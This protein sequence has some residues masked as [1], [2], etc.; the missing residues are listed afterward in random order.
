[1]SLIELFCDVDDF[2]KTFVPKWEQKQLQ[3][4]SRKRLR[5]SQLSLSEI[6]TIMILFHQSSYR[7]FKAFYIN[8]MQMYLKAEFP[9]LVSYPRF[10]ALMPRAFGPLCAYLSS[11]FGECTGVS[12]VDSTPLA[13][14]H[15]RRIKWHRVF[16]GLAERGKTSMGWFYGFK[17]HLVVNEKGELL[18][19]QFTPGNV[20]DRVPV[21]VLAK[22][23]SGKLFGDR[24]YI[25]QALFEQLWQDHNLFLVTKIR[26][27]MK[28]RLMLMI[29]KILL[30][31]RAVI[32][33]IIDQLKNISQIEHTRHRSPLN[34]F[35]NVL[36]GLI[37][38][39]HRPK[40]PSLN[41]G[42]FASSAL[43]IHN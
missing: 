43:L 19:V 6:M 30:R 5:K 34:F 15:N 13:I 31:K 25:S 22:R 32:E 9:N 39:C 27:N 10:V 40:K 26:K 4:G 35:V 1:M 17:L 16:A 11:L 8:H 2:C 20:D 12:F 37:A 42:N 14:C 29:D 41:L 38:Y 18:G 21:P 7:T 3:N 23:L 24:G 36:A 28:N 33:S